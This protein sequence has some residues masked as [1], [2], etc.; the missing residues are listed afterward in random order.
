MTANRDE[1]LRGNNGICEVHRPWRIRRPVMAS[2]TC[3][4]WVLALTP[5]PHHST[6]AGWLSVSGS[7]P[8]RQM[9]SGQI[10]LVT[11][12]RQEG[13]MKE[14][15]LGVRT[16]RLKVVGGLA[17]GLGSCDC[18]SSLYN[19]SPHRWRGFGARHSWP[20]PA[21]SAGWLLS[22][23]ISHRS[24]GAGPVAL[25]PIP[26]EPGIGI[27]RHLSK[28]APASGDLG[29]RASAAPS[30]FMSLSHGTPARPPRRCLFP[31]TVTRRTLAQ[32]GHA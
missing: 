28:A 5:A 31:T 3:K 14:A 7:A 13:A 12:S 22:S 9:P 25:A 17:G 30:G 24:A 15:A 21:R 2:A 4:E 8:V 19:P 10:W 29:L 27:A 6:L 1:L 23:T 16:W 26:E 32:P 20:I 18:S 11:V